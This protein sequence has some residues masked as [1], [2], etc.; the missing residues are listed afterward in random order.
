MAAFIAL[1]RYTEK[2]LQNIKDP[3]T[4]TEEFAKAARDAKVVLKEAA[5][6]QGRYDLIALLEAPDEAALAALTSSLAQQSQLQFETLPAHT[7]A[8]MQKIVKDAANSAAQPAERDP[9]DRL[10]VDEVA[11]NLTTS[12]IVA[13]F[14]AAVGGF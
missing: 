4:R 8:E 5:W 2:G 11:P 1:A 14:Q 6:T 10:A 9:R 12:A 7:A 13:G 3:V